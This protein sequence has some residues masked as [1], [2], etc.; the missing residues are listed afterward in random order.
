MESNLTHPI[1]LI[2][3]ISL[4]RVVISL[5]ASNIKCIARYIC[6]PSEHN[7]NVVIFSEGNEH[8]KQFISKLCKCSFTDRKQVPGVFFPLISSSISER[9]ADFII[10]SRSKTRDLNLQV[11]VFMRLADPD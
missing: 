3:P 5:T 11:F 8:T 2:Y 6:S 9:E 4:K 7:E 1:P 10:V